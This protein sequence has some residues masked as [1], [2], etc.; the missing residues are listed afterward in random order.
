MLENIISFIILVIILSPIW[1]P[2]AIITFPIWGLALFGLWAEDL[3]DI[4]E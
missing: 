4:D 3:H 2:L 1:I